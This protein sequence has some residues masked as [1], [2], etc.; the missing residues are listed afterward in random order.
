LLATK[1]Y[2]PSTRPGLVSRPHLVELLNGGLTGRLILVSAP[3]GFGKTTL[4]AEWIRS[5]GP[6]GHPALAP[7]GRPGGMGMT[8]AWLSLDAGENDP[9]R[10]WAYVIRALKS[11]HDELGESALAALRSP[12]PP[13][14]ESILV[15]LINQISALPIKEHPLLLVLDDYHLIENTQIH[16]ALAFLLDNLPPQFHLVIATR[17]DPPLPLARYRSRGQ[18][19]EVRADDLR[20]TREETAV[21]FNQVE[22][23]NLSAGDVTALAARTEGWIV[24][25]KMAVLSLQGR[26]AQHASDFIQAFSGSHHYVLDYLVE[27]VLTLQ[28]ES[29]Q[30]FLLQTSILERLTGSLCDAVTGRSDGQAMLEGLERAN[31]FL[32]PLDD[33]RHWYRYH[34]LFADLLR[35]RLRQFLPGSAARL[36]LRACEWFERHGHVT[37]A[38]NHALAAGDFELA[39]RL[40]EGH[41][42][43]LMTRGELTT[44]LTWIKALPEELAYN[45]P[46]LCISLG[47]VYTFAGQVARVEPLLRN[48]EDQ[49]RDQEE[50]PE[51]RDVLGN[52]AS[53][54]AFMAGM[55]GDIKRAI[56]LAHQADEL[57][58]GDSFIARSVLPFTLGIAYRGEGD[59]EKSV[60]A[61]DGVVKL[62]EAADNIWTISLGLFEIATTR[63]L[64]GRLREAA[65]ISRKAQGLAA[66]RGARYFASIGKVDAGLSEVLREQN[67][68]DAA[69]DLATQSLERMETWGMP[70]D[71]LLAYLSLLQVQAAQGDLP[72]AF[73]T[74]QKAEELKGKYLVFPR[75][76]KVVDMCRVRLALAAGDLNQA[77]AWVR[78]TQPG[79]QGTV[80][81]REMELIALARVRIAQQAWDDAMDVLTRLE[82]GARAGGRVAALIEILALEAVTLHAQHNLARALEV[83]GQAISLAEPEGYVRLFLD[84]GGPMAGLLRQAASRGIA[85]QYVGGLLAAFEAPAP[86]GA[87]IVPAPRPS[88][89]VEPL[90][91]RELEVLRLIAAGLSN[92]EIA[93]KLVISIRTVKKHVQN[94]HGKLDVRSRTQAIARAREL[95]LL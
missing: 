4:L 93:D 47:W 30:D 25:L 29:V 48:A 94:I 89:L 12:Q 43:D 54:R 49:V 53:I 33:E 72:G 90:S 55:A 40:I 1:L 52:I 39:A 17:A 58:P 65:E 36:H 62:G 21:L 61:L 71:L 92:Q 27:E 23:L 37:E 50:T 44:L 87:G 66:E 42:T 80:I 38:V 81:V 6:P 10:F 46:G 91:E 76:S 35:A 60:A 67:Q 51:A 18:L 26:R 31:L 24:G 95:N 73:D 69:R 5:L 84:A 20:F 77:E 83:L 74:L 63:R 41:S 7:G 85:P 14:L 57:L 88:A 9:A 75:L 64:Q 78:M 82:Q 59:F 15:A 2:V 34:H 16:E 86:A 79:S 28:P 11:M 13:P 32:V 45:R 19:I 3:A 22:G 70:A 56:E 68:L 8:V